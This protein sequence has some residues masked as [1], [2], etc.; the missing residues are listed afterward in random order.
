MTDRK[1][2]DR[3]MTGKYS[4][5]LFSWRILTNTITYYLI[6]KYLL[7]CHGSGKYNGIL[8]IQNTNFEFKLLQK[9]LDP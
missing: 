3:E 6:L 8:Q 1:M 7:C 5:V 4:L 9:T 2:I